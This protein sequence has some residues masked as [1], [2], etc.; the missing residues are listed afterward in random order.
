MGFPNSRIPIPQIFP[1]I[2]AQNID[3]SNIYICEAE[4]Y[5]CR[6]DNTSSN[7]DRYIITSGIMKNWAVFTSFSSCIINLIGFR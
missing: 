5:T 1:N 6:A 3:E 4:G 2:P 7:A